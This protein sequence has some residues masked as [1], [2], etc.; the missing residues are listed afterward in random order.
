MIKIIN[1]QKKNKRRK[2]RSI[3]DFKL[4]LEESEVRVQDIYEDEF[5]STLCDSFNVD[6]VIIKQ[7]YDE[8]EKEEII[9][10]VDNLKD[11]LTYMNNINKFNDGIELI[12]KEIKVV[13]KLVILREEYEKIRTYEDINIDEEVYVLKE[14]ISEPIDEDGILKINSIEKEL[15]D[16]NLFTKDIELLKKILISDNDNIIET[17]DKEKRLKKIQIH[18]PDSIE[19]EYKATRV[20]TVQ[21]KEFLHNNI[22]KLYRV[23][24]MIHKYIDHDKERSIGTINQSDMLQDTI[25]IAYATYDNIEFKAI[26]GNMDIGGFCETMDNYDV[27]SFK[28][29]AVNRHG[30]SGTGYDRKNDSEKKILEKI[31]KMIEYNQ[32]KDNGHLILNTRLE[33]CDSCYYVMS[34]FL[35]KHPRVIMTVR[36]DMKYGLK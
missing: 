34:Q 33:P 10:N 20:G 13:D 6:K 36:Y 4:L 25:N 2:I 19:Y 14:K 3:R 11:I 1:V 9:F 31:D 15:R 24:D 8:L 12:N 21:H 26:S 18:I 29:F 32:L 5:I 16:R 35:K 23:A 7:L 27:E 22:N 28:S 30:V 17:Y